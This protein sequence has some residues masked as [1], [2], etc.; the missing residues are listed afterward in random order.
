MS[1]KRNRRGHRLIRRLAESHAV[2]GSNN[3]FVFWPYRHKMPIGYCVAMMNGFANVRF[4]KST[5]PGGV[6]ARCA[7]TRVAMNSRFGSPSRNPEQLEK[8]NER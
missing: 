8:K 5:R 4:T 3:N 1:T 7:F 2:T 6:N